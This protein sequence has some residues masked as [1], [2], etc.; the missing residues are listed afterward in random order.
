MKTTLV[1]LLIALGMLGCKTSNDNAGAPPPGYETVSGQEQFMTPPPF[2]DPAGPDA[3][4]RYR[5]M[6]ITPITPP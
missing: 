1:T 2:K 3:W 6:G 5:Y 4:Q